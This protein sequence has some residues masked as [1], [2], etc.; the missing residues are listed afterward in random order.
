MKDSNNKTLFKLLIHGGAGAILRDKLTPEREQAFRQILTESLFAGHTILAEKGSSVDA[1]VAAITFLE[2]S[3]LFNAGK[4]AVFNHEGHIEL[5]A[6]IMDGATR[7]AGAVAAVTTIRNPICAAHKVMTQSPYVM[8][9]GHGAEVYAAEQNLELVD[10]TYFYTQH[11][12]DQLKKAIAKEKILLD[13]DA[14][15]DEKY[16]TVGAVALDCYGN[17]AAG[18]STG[19]L[20]NKRYG[21]IG[22]SPIIGA[23]TYAD[24]RSIAVSA[25]GS[26]EMFIRTAAAFNTAAYVRMK[27]IPLTEAVERTLE[28]ITAIGGAGGLIALDTKGNYAMQFNTSGMYRGMIDNNGVAWTG[29]F[30]DN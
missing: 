16:G 6:S 20:T 27:Q 24:N 1:V 28:E 2:D 22:D 8:L 18:T 14:E 25:T 3:P 12:W 23:G 17:L 10:P 7:M 26:G 13:H 15:S 19:G 5:D 9:I 11:R 30:A 21:R 29:I 4:G